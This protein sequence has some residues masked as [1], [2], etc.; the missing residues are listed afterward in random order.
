MQLNEDQEAAISAVFSFLMSDAREMNI[1]GPA[2]VGKTFLMKK[3]ANDV[4]KEYEH[5]CLLLGIKPINYEVVLTATTNKA[6]EVL[7]L[8]T[9]FPV[10]TIHSH[11]N[12]KVQDDYT[13]G[14]SKITKTG[15]WVVHSRQIIFIDEA[16]MVDRPLHKYL[17]EGTDSTC[18]IIYIGDHCQMAPVMETISPVY[19]GTVPTVHLTKPVRNAE[20]PVLQALCSQARDTVETL[21]FKPIL[22]VPGVIDYLTDAEAQAYI[23]TVFKDEI[24]TERVLCYSN[25][26]VQEYNTYIRALRGYPDLFTKG[27]ILVNNT[28]FQIGKDMLRVEQDVQVFDVLS[29]EY[30]IKI[31]PSDPDVEMMVYDL[32]I[33]HPGFSYGSWTVKVPANPEHYKALLNYYSKQK[34]WT[35]FYKLKNGHPDLRAKAAATVYKAQGSTYDTVLMDLGDIGKCTKPDQAARMLYV[36][37]SRARSRVLLYGDLPSRYVGA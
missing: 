17:I 24:Q 27:E 1:S 31:D 20:Q 9:G 36:G 33:G 37:V 8:S 35:L 34:N 16:S 32:L 2:G 28:A 15:S 14:V 10:K 21:S 26:K 23:D 11:M 19:A 25:A 29:S 30:P 5:S 22:P 12:L 3:I 4:L 7:A 6:A 18:K 13:T